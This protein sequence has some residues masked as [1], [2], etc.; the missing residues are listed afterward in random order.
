MAPLVKFYP[1]AEAWVEAAVAEIFQRV[2]RAFQGKDFAVML[3]SGGR[4]PLP[5][6]RRLALPPWDRLMPW[7]KI[8]FFWADERWVPS[9]HPESNYGMVW[10]SLLSKVPA[11]RDNIHRICTDS[12]DPGTSARE[13]EQEWRDFSAQYGEG[14]DLALMGMGADGHVAS[15]FPGDPAVKEKVRLFMETRSPAGIED[16]I[17]VTF[18][19]LNTSSDV[20]FLVSGAEKRSI[21]EKVLRKAEAAADG[22]PAT[23]VRAKE[24]VLWILD[25]QAY[26]FSNDVKKV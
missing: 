11:N 9:E 4:T 25:E 6:Y 24:R 26:S 18:P 5:V 10:R 8:H 17:T 16:R 2:S 21:L 12:S 7:G 23:M 14:I 19:L 22:I 3:L 20:I 1:D 15:M 13:Y